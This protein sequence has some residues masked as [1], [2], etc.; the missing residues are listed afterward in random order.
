[1]KY[2]I[3]VLWVSALSSCKQ[4]TDNKQL[5]NRIDS[6]EIQLANSYKPGFGELMSS[7]QTHHAK[8]WFAGQNEN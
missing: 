5:Q 4:Q 3:L 2:I 8:L 6:L 1:M 7:I